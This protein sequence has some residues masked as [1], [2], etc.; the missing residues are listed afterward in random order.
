MEVTDIQETVPQPSP[1]PKAAAA[2]A[3]RNVTD[4]L[5]RSI[6]L[7][8]LKPSERFLLSKVVD[9]TNASTMM[10]AI[11]AASVFSIDD[12]GFTPIRSE[13]ELLARLDQ[14]GD[15]GLLAIM[16]AIDEMYGTTI[17]AQDAE[18]AKN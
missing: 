14:V 11:A 13:K 4:S 9:M 10:Q 8:K 17:S 1:T 3:I 7:K 2:P 12:E 6:G 15:E 18:A 5:G 16:P